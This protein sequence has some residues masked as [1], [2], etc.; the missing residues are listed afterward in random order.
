V[1]PEGIIEPVDKVLATML[2]LFTALETYIDKQSH[3]LAYASTLKRR[4]EEVR[5]L[6]G[7]YFTDELRRARA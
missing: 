2:T 1:R 4:L 7:E 6:I 3:R 5:S